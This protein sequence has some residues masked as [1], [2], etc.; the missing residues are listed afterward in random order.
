MR[1]LEELRSKSNSVIGPVDPDV[2]S[3]AAA[4]PAP[5]GAN[6]RPQAS[7]TPQRS[8]PTPPTGGNSRDF[9]VPGNGGGRGGG[10]IDPVTGC[11]VLGLAAACA[12]AA[13]RR[14]KS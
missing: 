3:V 9:N 11:A 1:E 6:P 10:A 4:I 12:A 5:R 14:A 2:V 7:S 13:R 8:N